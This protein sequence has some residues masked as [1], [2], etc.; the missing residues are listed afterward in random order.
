MLAELRAA[1]VGSLAGGPAFRYLRLREPPYDDEALAAWA[2]R[3]RALVREGIEVYC[4]FK[5]EDEPTGPLYA[6]RVLELAYA[7]GS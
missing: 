1:R 6:S 2:A 3:M 5:H 7:P 4:Y